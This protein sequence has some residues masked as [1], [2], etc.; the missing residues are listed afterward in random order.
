MSL[1]PLL[2]HEVNRQGSNGASHH[3]RPMDIHRF[4]IR[5]YGLLLHEGRVL[6]ADERIQG[7]HITK[8]PGGGMEFG[9]GPKECLIREIR[10]EIGVEAFGLEHF[11]TTDFFQESAFRPGDQIISIYFTMR[12]VDP[13]SIPVNED[14]FAFGRGEGDE[15]VFRWL[16]LARAV[17]EDASLPIDRVVLGLLKERFNQHGGAAPSNS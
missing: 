5:V 3:L 10:E 15:E 7:R 4:N 2:I 6:L 12:V 14:P 13:G 9:E 1:V 8:F 16:A 11:Y 17:P